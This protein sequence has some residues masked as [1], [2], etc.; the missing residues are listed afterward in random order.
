MVVYTISTTL[1]PVAI[2]PTQRQSAPSPPAVLT[3]NQTIVLGAL[4]SSVTISNT[5][6]TVTATADVERACSEWVAGELQ[7]N[8]ILHHR[9]PVDR[10]IIRCF[11]GERGTQQHGKP[12][13]S[14]HRNRARPDASLTYNAANSV[15]G[16]VLILPQGSNTQSQTITFPPLPSVQYGNTF[17]LSASSNPP[18]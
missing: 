17:S 15:S 6:L 13:P 18:A 14:P 16:T 8:G 3:N 9:Q 12:A 1:L 10:P 11:L 2:D 7:R 4:P 5:P